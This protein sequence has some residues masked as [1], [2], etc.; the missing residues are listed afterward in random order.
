MHALHVPPNTKGRSLSLCDSQ[1][2]NTHRIFHDPHKY[3][4]LI[5][6]CLLSATSAEVQK[7]YGL[8]STFCDRL[9]SYV[10]TLYPVLTQWDAKQRTIRLLAR[11]HSLTSVCKT[12]RELFVLTCVYSAEKT[13]NVFNLFS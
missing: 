9:F 1:K 7:L 11:E 13:F 2:K 10:T 12:F 4:F 6:T 5:S 3:C 8:I